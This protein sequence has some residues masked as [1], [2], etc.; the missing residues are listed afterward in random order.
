MYNLNQ[1]KTKIQFINFIN[2]IRYNFIKTIKKTTPILLLDDIYDKL[3][4]LRV[5]QLMD[6]VSSDKFGQLFITDTHPTR[7]SDLFKSSNTDFKV[8]KISKGTIEKTLIN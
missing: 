4:D 3:D 2:C 1:H 7:L 5:K 8:F 6:L